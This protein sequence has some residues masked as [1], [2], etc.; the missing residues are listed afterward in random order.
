MFRSLARLSFAALVS[1]VCAL[2]A[3]AAPSRIAESVRLAP[4]TPGAVRFTVTTPEPRITRVDAQAGVDRLDFHLDQELE[5][6]AR[7]A[8]GAE[9]AEGLDAFLGKREPQFART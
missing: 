1:G 6:L 4:A 8:D 3:P 5:N 9:F 7:S 2:P